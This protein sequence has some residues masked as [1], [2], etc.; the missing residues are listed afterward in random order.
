MVRNLNH[1]NT[2]TTMKQN[3]L[4][5][6]IAFLFA[7]GCEADLMTPV[8]NEGQD[9][10]IVL[11]RKSSENVPVQYHN[12][13]A[14]DTSYFV[15]TSDLEDMVRYRYPVTKSSS[16]TAS[17]SFDAIPYGFEE[18][19]TLLYIVNYSTGNWEI[20]SAD[21]RAPLVIA[22]GEGVFEP[23][24]TANG[25]MVYVNMLAG[26]ILELRMNNGCVLDNHIDN[27]MEWAGMNDDIIQSYDP[28]TKSV[29]NYMYPIWKTNTSTIVEKVDPLLYTKWGQS[30]KTYNIYNTYC[31]L[32]T[33]GSGKRA[34]VGC[35]VVAGAQVL[36]YLYKTLG[37][38][39]YVPNWASCVGNVKNYTQEFAT[40]CNVYYMRDIQLHATD[41]LANKDKYLSIFLAWVG[42]KVGVRY[43]DDGSYASLLSLLD[44]FDLYKID[45]THKDYFDAN[46]AINSI[47]AG[48]PV[49]VGGY[50]I[51]TKSEGS[52]KS[53]H[54]WV[55]D[56]YKRQYTQQ[57]TY[58]HR[59]HHELTDEEISALTRA[60]INYEIAGNKI[61]T[62]YFNMNWGWSGS[63]D[64]FFLISPD[65]W[66]P[67]L[68][69]DTP[70]NLD[71]DMIY[72]FK[73]K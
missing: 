51:E 65:S 25:P 9:F 33:T 42:N 67:T 30:H 39:V 8:E 54:T 20:I 3:F 50:K 46:I 37:V 41:T 18:N 12:G 14:L 56:G 62:E 55:I 11:K 71:Q 26:Q 13:N 70:Y 32:K 60:D 10:Q 73:K 45:C 58:Y 64:G 24:T 52:D 72:G 68:P 23:D 27:V 63:Y 38:S 19:Q 21:K 22:S 57:T 61:Y 4:Y 49:I 2:K 16:D 66:D 7:V 15:T 28:E 44:I 48:M 36:H 40:S 5:I 69:K 6:C 34:S 53:G 43:T 31:P 1:V 59:S 47:K 17:L 35:T 29:I